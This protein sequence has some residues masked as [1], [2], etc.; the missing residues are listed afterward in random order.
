MQ[1]TPS[2]RVQTAVPRHVEGDFLLSGA[3][4]SG[5]FTP[6]DF[7]D[8]HRLVSESARAFYEGDVAPA[9]K[10]LEQHNYEMVRE[11]LYRAAQQGFLGTEIP[12]SHGGYGLGLVAA[13][14][15]TEQFARH[16]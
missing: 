5:I 3:V 4:P 14:L 9:G 2:T 13:M 6:K 15:Q 10:A 7:T 16:M 11:L 1:M 8:E 12:E